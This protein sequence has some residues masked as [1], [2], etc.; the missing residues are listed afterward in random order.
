[1]LRQ[2]VLGG[3]PVS[4]RQTEGELVAGNLAVEQM[5]QEASDRGS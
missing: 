1:M 4:G 5:D 2:N 3:R